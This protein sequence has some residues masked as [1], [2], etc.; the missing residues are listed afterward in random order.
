M[1]KAKIYYHDIGDYLSQNE[2]LEIIQKFKSFSNMPLKELK[3]NEH[4]DWINKRNENFG[5][6]IPLAPEK[7][8][9]LKTQS[10]FNTNT[11]GT[12]TARDSWVYN[13]SKTI[14]TNNIEKTINYYN[15]ER[16]QI[17]K[18]VINEVTLNS[19]LGSW[20]RDWKN[21]LEKNKI[22]VIDDSE[23]RIGL[24]RPFIKSNLYFED[25]LIQERYQIPKMLPNN[26]K[27]NLF[28][29]LTGTAGSKPFS[30]IISEMIPN[31]DTIE[32]AQ[33]FPLYYY[34]ENNS[35][36]KGL[37]D[38]EG[39][40]GFIRR[41]AISDFILERAKKQYGLSAN[42][43]N[44]ITKEDIFYYVY[45]FLHSKE[46]RETFA[47]DL[48]KML[49][50][51]PL[52]NDV[53]DFWA[54]SKAGRKLADLHL[55]YETVPPHDEVIVEGAEKLSFIDNES[56]NSNLY[57]VEKMRFPKKTQKDTIIYNSKI[58]IKN[59]PDKAY[60]YIVNGKSAIEWILERYQI[61]TDKKSGITNDPNDWA[62]EH[63]QPRYILDLLLSIIN[64]SVQT[65]DIVDGLPKVDF[66]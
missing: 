28:I 56:G 15:I 5:E 50:R 51:L 66:E 12:V 6:Y 62:K 25:D 35:S 31:L 38:E 36:Q 21:N 63:N 39:D 8:F 11:L 58:T 47:N 57:L 9:D 54:F 40:N 41:D 26:L 19:K 18:K 46:Y 7:K 3:P 22:F 55:N 4:G 48:K 23:F 32:K 2:K 45:G 61:T 20:S 1:S 42:L 13:F 10:F 29:C 44:T 14:L 49:P 59:I 37:F 27:K 65:V 33:C 52:V 16:E 30:T 34:E 17:L 60:E 53:R 64:V 43:K 24:Y